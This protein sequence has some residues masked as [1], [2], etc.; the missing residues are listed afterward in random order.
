[1]KYSICLVAMREGKKLN[2]VYLYIG[3]GLFL[4]ALAL[5]GYFASKK[6]ANLDDFSVGGRSFGPL[7]IAIV[8]T[9]TYGS[10]SSYVGLGGL[11]FSAGW[12][13]MWIWVGCLLGIVLPILLLGPKMRIFSSRLNATTLPD[14]LGKRYNS[15]FLRAFAAIGTIVFYIPNMVAQFKGVGVLFETVLD[16][17]FATAVL[18]FGF[19]IIIY[20]A[21]GGI[22]AV[23]WTDTIQGLFMMLIVLALVPISISATGGLAE[24]NARL[25]EIGPAMTKMFGNGYTPGLAAYIIVFY[26]LLQMGQPNIG[27]RFFAIKNLKDF[28]KV[29][30][31]V[32]IGSTVMSSMI[33]GG[34]AARILY[35]DIQGDYS[36]PIIIQNLFPPLLAVAAVVGIMA[37]MMTTIDSLLH[38]IATAIGIDLI[39][40][41]FNFEI[42]DT[43]VLKITRIST[44]LV[45][46]LAMFL[47]L[48]YTPEFLSILVF[49]ALAGVG[50]I[51]VGPVV[52][53]VLDSKTNKT[54]AIAGA[55]IG[56]AVFLFLLVTSSAPIF[57]T[58]AITLVLNIVVTMVV[59]RLAGKPDEEMSELLF[60]LS[61]K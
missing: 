51:T 3:L 37:A 38:V 60:P 4:M 10:A 25:T 35:P 45:G 1:M 2:K 33:W 32:L 50:S 42:T 5:I 40:N 58:G 43:Q 36:I 16:I 44:V 47:T 22:F 55:V 49:G 26:C 41:T 59:S 56:E 39:K 57:K 18:V 61:E 30:I 9:S 6:T 46:F 13:M 7:V 14:F 53:G 54:G 21:A 17:P 24:M 34:L 15:K 48:Y 23:A 11:A 12:P 29:V 8:I 19:V 20:C 31:Y 28:K 27:S 52:M